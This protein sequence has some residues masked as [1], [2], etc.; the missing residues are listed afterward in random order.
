MERADFK[1]LVQQCALRHLKLHI[2]IISNIQTYI[3]LLADSNYQ[4]TGYIGNESKLE[5]QSET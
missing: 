1:L 3:K 5:T 2:K 4:K